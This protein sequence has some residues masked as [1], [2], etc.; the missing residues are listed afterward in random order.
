ML[1]FVIAYGRAKRQRRTHSRSL[2]AQAIVQAHQGNLNVQS[3]LGKGSTFTILLPFNVT[4]FEG[5]RSIYQL[6]WLSRRPR[7]FQ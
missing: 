6:K 4:P 5:V 7:K 3:E 2:N 1:S